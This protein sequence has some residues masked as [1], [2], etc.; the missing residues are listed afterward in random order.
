MD[1]SFLPN[2]NSTSISVLD[3]AVENGDIKVGDSLKTAVL[4]SL[5]SDSRS[6]GGTG[7]WWGDALDGYSY[8]SQLWTLRGCKLTKDNLNL[9][10]KYAKNALEWLISDGI[11]SA[12]NVTA[13]REGIDRVSLSVTIQ[14]PSGMAQTYK[15]YTIWSE[16]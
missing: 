1:I 6:Q 14:R 4:M 13:S 5:F 8:G 16:L 15:Y 10:Q 11:A 2:A 9:I 3:V 7:G 12:V